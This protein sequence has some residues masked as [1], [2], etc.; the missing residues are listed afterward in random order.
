MKNLSF[1]TIVFS[2]VIFFCSTAVAQINIP[3]QQKFNGPNFPPFWT[4][5]STLSP[6]WSISQ[7][8][9][10][11][12]TPNEVMFTGT[13]GIG[14]SRL[15]VGPINTAGFSILTLQFAQKLSCSDTAGVA[16]RIQS[17]TDG[18]TWVNEGYNLAE[19][20]YNCADVI[21][22]KILQN[23]G[24]TTYLSF[25]IIGNHSL[26]DM[27]WIDEVIISAYIE[28]DVGINE[29]ATTNNPCFHWFSYLNSGSVTQ[30][31]PVQYTLTGTD[32]SIDYTRWV[33][34]L[35][36]D[37]TRSVFDEMDFTGFSSLT[38]CSQ[39]QGDGNPLNDCKTVDL[40]TTLNPQFFQLSIDI[41]DNW[42][43]VSIPGRILPAPLSV[44]T[45]WPGRDPAAS[46][47][48]F[49]NGYQAVTT[50][51]PGRGY[52]MRNAGNIT[53][54]TGDEW[55][56]QGIRKMPHFP[57]V[58]N[59]GWQLIGAY[60]RP[61]PVNS[62][63]SI[64][65]GLISSPFYEFSGGYQVADTLEAGFA[66]WVKTSG[67]GKL[68][69]DTTC[70]STLP[71]SFSKKSSS[72]ELF[73]EEF[74][75][76]IITD[77]TGKSYTLFAVNSQTD[78]EKYE[79]PPPPPAGIF[80]IRYSSGRIAEEISSQKI[81]EM[82]GVK[83][84]VTIKVENMTG[85]IKDAY[86]NELN[87]VINPGEE[88]T[89]TNSLIDKLI[90]Q[91]DDFT[92]ADNYTLEQNYPNPFNPVTTINYSLAQNNFVSLTVYDVLGREVAT[93]VDEF[94]EAGIYEVEFDGSQLASGV[95]YYQLKVGE[96]VQTKK[97]ILTK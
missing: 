82:T 93:L 47:Y 18:G 78:L 45:W 67:Y 12:G 64:P 61:F 89:I 55:P 56:A 88:L 63:I 72:E 66:Y 27:D 81:I 85:L 39:L 37:A 86:G 69:I 34:N 23:V 38:V 75:R 65:P 15:I 57:I 3:Y 92:Q 29:Y 90:V 31:F 84:P 11:G 1:L 58:V 24:L 41:A 54:N 87:S 7:S 14:V 33:Y 91:S 97:M 5:T 46:V 26:I 44:D 96:F 2:T 77:A 17:S 35:E 4:Q 43:I 95:Y 48:Q 16:L 49:D 19:N 83:Y 21:N 73:K 32:T 70:V 50:V 28:S 68:I 79:L 80:D 25:T 42:N 8:A 60:E 40:P 36:P 20:V 71:N 52:W 76:I 13:A 9:N 22:I 62:I 94:R 51:E 53:Y 30:S 10:A 59:D 6:R 74:G